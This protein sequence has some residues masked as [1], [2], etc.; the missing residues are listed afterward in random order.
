[1]KP[2][3]STGNYICD[4]HLNLIPRIEIGRFELSRRT[5][6]KLE[7]E[8]KSSITISIYDYCKR[9]TNNYND[10]MEAI[11]KQIALISLQ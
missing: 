4:I 9:A 2:K 10:V 7:K 6:N 8:Y 11:K 3:R 1:M 5:M